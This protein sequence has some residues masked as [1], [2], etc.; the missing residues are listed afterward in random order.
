[1]YFVD[2][3]IFPLI[4]ICIF[5]GKVFHQFI[6]YWYKFINCYL[7]SSWQLLYFRN[8]GVYF[9]WQVENVH[10]LVN[11]Y[12]GTIFYIVVKL[13][14]FQEMMITTNLSR[15]YM[16]HV[17]QRNIFRRRRQRVDLYSMVSPY[18]HN[19]K[20]QNTVKEV[21]LCTD[22]EKPRAI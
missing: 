11:I 16:A 19:R 2:L 7:L 4:L 3:K 1:M 13:S 12:S 18:H 5:T 9:F 8:T 20:Q 6:K 15:S 17:P 10:V 14:I 21:L 22:C